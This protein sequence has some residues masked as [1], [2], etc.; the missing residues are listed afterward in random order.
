MMKR[1]I[2]ICSWATVLLI[3]LGSSPGKAAQVAASVEYDFV[4]RPAGLSPDFGQREGVS[5]RFLAIK[6]IDEFRVDAALW[7]PNGKQ[8]SDTT[9]LVMVHG[10]GGSYQGAPQSGLGPRLA[11]RGYASLAINTRQHDDKINTD[12]F[13]DVRRDIDAAV[14]V[15]RALGYKTLVLQGHSLGNI[16][17]QFYAATN[18]DRD[19]RAVILLGA[20]AN[21]PW[22]SRNIL[23]QDEE[24]YRQLADASMKSLRD[25]TLDQILP[26]KMRF[27]TPVS[28]AAAEAP[29]TGQHFLTYRWEKT[30]IADGTFW[31]HRI[32]QPVLMIR[33]QAD[34]AVAPFEP[35]MLLSAAH[36]EGSLPPK[37]DF[38]LL[39]DAKPPSLKGHSFDGNEEP[40]ADAITKW[41]AE[42]HL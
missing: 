17:V 30:S 24:R 9:L 18:W 42:L 37:V 34:G 26:V 40:L 7:Q 31:I 39:P 41:L 19:T 25:G 29:I 6:T 12:N 13:L 3:A 33:D 2:P 5:V 14:Q 20:F 36:S 38:I 16:Q 21:L 28:S 27:A 15:G 22:K 4:A 8:A 1:A 23:V 32:P 35:H 10:S 11:A